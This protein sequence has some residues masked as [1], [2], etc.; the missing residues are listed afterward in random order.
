[1]EEDAA[2]QHG[3]RGANP[4]QEGPFI[5]EGETV[6]RG[7]ALFLPMHDSNGHE[8]RPRRFQ[9]HFRE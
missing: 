6:V 1:M 3:E 8:D 2:G 4:S 5:G 7:L 9:G